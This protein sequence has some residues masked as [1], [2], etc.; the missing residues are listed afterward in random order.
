MNEG[1]DL[2]ALKSRFDDEYVQRM[3]KSSSGRIGGEVRRIND[4]LKGGLMAESAEKLAGKLIDACVF[5]N[6]TKIFDAMSDN[7]KDMAAKSLEI[8]KGELTP[9]HI[10]S[11][12]KSEI[13]Q[14]MIQT[15]GVNNYAAYVQ[16]LGFEK[17][18]LFVL[19]VGNNALD[20]TKKER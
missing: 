14:T 4:M 3:A 9:Y 2:Q 17:L 18:I 16:K 12:L 6:S 11:F 5:K 1:T 10:T 13:L 7:D 19:A 8:S 15:Q 20:E